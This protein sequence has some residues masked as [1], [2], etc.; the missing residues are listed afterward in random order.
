MLN[1]PPE[2]LICPIVK[3]NVSIFIALFSWNSLMGQ[4]R[5]RVMNK[6]VEYNAWTLELVN[7]QRKGR[8]KRFAVYQSIS[9]CTSHFISTKNHYPGYKSR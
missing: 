4:F 8:E 5:K 3:V 7:R 1:F 2:L 6:H 9:T